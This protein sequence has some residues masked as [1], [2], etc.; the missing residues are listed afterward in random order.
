MTG[1]TEA[2]ESSALRVQEQP[3]SKGGLAGRGERHILGKS[4]EK[5]KEDLTT[6]DMCG[7]ET[8][9]MQLRT[10]EMTG[11]FRGR[12]LQVTV[13]MHDRNCDAPRSPQPITAC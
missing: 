8:W 3:G 5:N 2:A 13:M 1:D 6:E 7:H 12:A 9:G 11:R 4:E 10:T